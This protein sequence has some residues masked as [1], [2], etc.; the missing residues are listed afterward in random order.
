MWSI[1]KSFKEKNYA[2]LFIWPVFIF[3]Q[4]PILTNSNS[5]KFHS[6][7]YIDKKIKKKI[8]YRKNKEAHKNKRK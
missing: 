5:D 2:Q 6:D 3:W 4:I 1:I 7:E 8:L